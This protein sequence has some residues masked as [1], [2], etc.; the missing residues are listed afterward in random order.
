[1]YP[2]N[3][4][5]GV[6]TT[7]MVDLPFKSRYVGT[8][9]YQVM[10]QNDAFLAPSINPNPAKSANVPAGNT[11]G[12]YALSRPSLDGRI[13][14]ILSNNQLTTQ[15]TPDLKIKT[16][17]R[18][19]EVDNKTAPMTMFDWVINDSTSARSQTAGYA[20]HSTIFQ[21][22]TKQ[23]AAEDINW[24]PWRWLDLG[25]I[26]GWE[27][28]DR[29]LAQANRTT[30]WSAKFYDVVSAWD[31]AKIRSSYFLSERRYS[32]YDWQTYVG[33]VIVAPI[34]PGGTT[35]S[36]IENPGMRTYDMADRD[37]QIG[38]VAVDLDLFP[39]LTLTPNAGL[40]FDR[41]L[42][43]PADPVNQL[44]L[45]KDRNWNVGLEASYT[46]NSL[47]TVFGAIM[48]E[49]YD[50]KMFDGGGVVAG[51]PTGH[52]MTDIVGHTNTF[53]GAL[54]IF[55]IPKTLDLK[56]SGTI[57]MSSDQWN[58]AAAPGGTPI[59]SNCPGTCSTVLGLWP[60]VNGTFRRFDATLRYKFDEDVT[61]KLGWNGDVYLKL[62]YAY[63]MNYVDNW[64]LGN[65]QQYMYYS[66][67]ARSQQLFMAGDN[68]NYSAQY[69]IATLA[70]KW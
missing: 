6:T 5:Q 34:V 13:D 8:L 18:Y 65:M 15:L 16:S 28:Y 25:A 51:A 36:L 10:T 59:V 38:K 43:N 26:V 49:A 17:Y 61:K 24:R 55:I 23:H 35:T 64:A 69:I 3:F 57:M 45:V 9:Q 48:T 19:Y 11:I 41:Y 32:N 33:N 50:R 67:N 46:V 66:A 30:E 63:E 7:T 47:L 20:P 68:P 54:D 56:L 40:R 29:S 27:Q 22:Y 1:M 42:T 58:N 37:R 44:G 53:V 60:E 62:K 12:N 4:A 31:W 2:S 39:G 21:S 52:Y 14:T 70:L